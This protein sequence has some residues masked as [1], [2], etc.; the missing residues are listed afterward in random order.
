[1]DYLNIYYNNVGK[2]GPLLLFFIS[3]FLLWKKSN[4]LIYYAFGFVL[5]AI[6][7]LVLKGIFKQPRPS[8]DYKLFNL[9][10][11]DSK[12]FKFIDGYSYDIFGMPSGHAS[13]VIYS[14]IFIYFVFKNNNFVLIYLLISIITMTQRIANND[15]TIIQIL[16]G[17]FVGLIFGY[18]IFYMA[19]QKIMGILLLKKDDNAPI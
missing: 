12:R 13:S 8:E 17:A 18:F 1:M 2:N 16:A 11:S 3:I 7:T 15:H 5:N 14:T 9:A 10:I 19:Q 6:L 4:Y